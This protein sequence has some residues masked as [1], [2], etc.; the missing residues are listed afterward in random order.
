MVTSETQVHSSNIPLNQNIQN[1]DNG[2]FPFVTQVFAAM[3]LPTD[4]TWIPSGLQLP[5]L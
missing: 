3:T 5:T 1:R 2:K 4:Q